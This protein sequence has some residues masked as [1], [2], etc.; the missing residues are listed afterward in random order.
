MIRFSDKKFNTQLRVC[1]NRIIYSRYFHVQFYWV[2]R[3]QLLEISAGYID[4][5]NSEVI[6]NF[7]Q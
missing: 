1:R 7:D 4:S 6:V 5:I 3:T 2:V